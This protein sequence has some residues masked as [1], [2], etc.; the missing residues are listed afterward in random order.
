MIDLRTI[1]MSYSVTNAI[2]AV[3]MLFLWMQNRK[4]LP[5]L[6]LWL[7]NFIMQFFTV[8]MVTLRGF[9][10]DFFS[11]VIANSLSVLGIILFYQG[12]E[13]FVIKRSQRWVNYS[14]LVVF[15]LAHAYFTYTQPSLLARNINFSITLLII[16]TQVGWLLFHRIDA[17]LRAE[18]NKIGFIFIAIGLVNIFR[19]ITTLGFSKGN[20]FFQS[21][22]FESGVMLAFQ[23]LFISLTFTLFLLVNQ[24]LVRQTEQ[25]FNIRELAEQALKQSEEKFSIIFQNIPDAILIVSFVSGKIIDTNDG[26]LNITQFTKADLDEKTTTEIDLWVNKSDRQNFFDRMNKDGRIFNFEAI[27]QKKDG[28]TFIGWI[29]GETIQLQEI[30]CILCVIRDITDRKKTEI[31][32]QENYSTLH[33]ILESTDAMI[34]S[35][36]RDCLYTSF[37]NAHT[38]NIK[39]RYNQDIQVGKNFLDYITVESERITAKQNVD[40]AM[41]GEYLVEEVYSDVETPDPSYFEISHAP[42]TTES[43]NII[44][45]SIFSKDITNRKKMELSLHHRLLELET[46]NN[47]SN[48]MRMGKNLGELVRI[49]LQETLTTMDTNDACILLLEPGTNSLNLTEKRG[50]FENLVGF[51]IDINNDVIQHLVVSNAPYVVFETQTN[52][53]FSPQTLGFEPPSSKGAFFSIRAENDLI[54]ILIISFQL[55]RLLSQNK[56]RLLTIISRLASTAISRSQLHDQVKMYNLDLQNEIE[57]KVSIQELLAAEKELLSTTLMSIADGV[58]VTDKD[59]YILLSNHSAELITGYTQAETVKQPVGNILKF[60]N[61]TTLKPVDDVINFLFEL[62]K[63]QQNTSGYRAPLAITK[64]GEKILLS[65]SITPLKTSADFTTGYVLVFQNINEKQKADAQKVLSQKMEAIGQ[66]AAGI[67]HEINTPTQ[68]VGDNIK[69]LGKAFSK[70]SETL[71]VYEQVIQEHQ[72]KIFT[73]NDLEQLATVARQKKVQ[74]YGSEIPKAI[75]EALEGTE[76][77]RKI[78]LA[79]R[80]FSHPSEK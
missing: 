23:I 20:D 63:A 34:C 11:I 42:I 30:K 59:G 80:E 12:L 41:S 54:G 46:V 10:P 22:N 3:V 18:T 13:I 55:P 47:L 38:Q 65:G 45:V 28:T 7:A 56:L 4:Q 58:I 37:N 32:L 51:S 15:M 66:L 43:D 8:V 17:R 77:I 67:A 71:A 27:F 53:L 60:Y 61:T 48:S 29:S 19:I 33:N 75:Q 44:G 73:Q 5:V 49:L 31:A 50:W 52:P 64:T 25:D 16:C 69:F 78:V 14:L 26:F 1:L 39:L 24:R 9:I 6:S 21:S 72:E 79:M 68:Y 35:I 70:Y 76:R 62:E 40:R 2:C 74:Y 57:Q 36:N